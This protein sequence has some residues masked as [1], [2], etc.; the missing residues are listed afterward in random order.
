MRVYIHIMVNSSLAAPNSARSPLGIRNFRRLWIGRTVSN[1]GDQCYLVALPWLVLQLTNSSLALGTIMMTATIPLAVLTLVG[2][3]MSDR[4]S[5]RKIWMASTAVR[6]MSVAI[7]GALVWFHDLQLWQIYVLALAF[8]VADAFA[9]PAAQTMVPSLVDRDQ[10]PAANSITQVTQQ[11]TTIVG[12]APAGLL[13][14]SLGVAWAFLIDAVS[15]LFIIGA[16]SGLPDP[17]RSQPATGRKGLLH[18]IWEGLIYINGDAAMRSL[19]ILAA[20]LNFSLSGT[21][22][23]GMAW[24]AN[25]DFASPV[26]FSIFLSSLALGSLAGLTLAGVYRPRHRGRMMLVV[27]A[28]I[29]VC[30]GVLGLATHVWLLTVVLV[31]MGAA[32]GFLNVHIISWFQQRVDRQMLGRATSVL[33]FAAVGLAPLSLLLAGIA[34]KWSVTGLFGASAALMFLATA[35]AA[36][37]RPIYEIR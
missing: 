12:P 14:K 25:H 34:V 18:A 36:S 15:F 35:V 7:A 22:S 27:S 9:G 1:V 6:A 33:M 16:L 19:L 17:P 23:I 24:I 5:P 26:V 21:L 13:I 20:A 8:G 30:T 29:A 3:A 37:T 11:L 31:V 32:A 28:L 10:L 4:F 2:G